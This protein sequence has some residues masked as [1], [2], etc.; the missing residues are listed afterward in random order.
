[1]GLIDGLSLGIDVALSRVNV[2]YC[3]LGV[4][5]GTFVGVIPGVGALAAISM[6]L[7]LSFYLDPTTAI[8]LLAGIYYGTVYGGSTAAI[9][10]NLPG[11]PSAAVACLD[12]YPMT[13]QGR[14]GVALFLTTMASFVGSML[15]LAALVFFADAISD[16]GLSLRP[17]DYFLLMTLGLVAAAAIP[18]GSPLKGLAMVFIGLAMGTVGTDIATGMARFT[19]GVPE[20]LDGLS[21]VA[22]AMGLFGI[23]EVIVTSS[24]PRRRASAG[25]I[26]LRSMIPTRQDLREGAMPMA[27]GA[28][29]GGLF[30]ALPGVGGTIAC[31]IS[32][33]VE[34]RLSRHPEKFGHGAVEGI[35]ASESANNSAVQ[36]AFIPSLT[37]G[38]PGDAVMALMLG[39]LIIHGI[40]PG[41]LLIEQ[42]PGMFW[43][44]V[45]SF[46]LGNIFLVILNIPLIGIWLKL[47][48]IP[49]HFMFPAIIVFICFGAFSVNGNAFDVW[50]L[51]ALGALGWMLSL[52]GFQPAPLL[53]GFILG[54]MIEE[55]LRRALQLSRG[56]FGTFVNDGL[57][58]SLTALIVVLV[59]LAVLKPVLGRRG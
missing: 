35:C 36:T 50:A 32:Y 23:S 18:T 25:G 48:S 5:I 34:K 51:G 6:I 27:R 41:P 19:F 47:L 13:R 31:F 46:I 30:G 16:I 33:A 38:I 24:L 2:A 11:V 8:V 4:L 17:A 58:V 26:T 49:Y 53:L 21:L 59:L 57:S 20:L 14:G 9:L 3:F 29:I 28:G 15:G 22:L 37:L 55:N 54:P 10:L 45:V 43:G 56:D 39:A 40:T 12:G 52:F 7:P 42:Q 44:L 1:M